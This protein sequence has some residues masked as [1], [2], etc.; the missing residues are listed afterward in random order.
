M[1]VWV[2]PGWG[3]GT[4]APFNGGLN[5]AQ[6]FQAID[7]FSTLLREARITL[8][9][10]SAG[11]KL[12]KDGTFQI[13]FFYEQFLAGVKSADRA[14]ADSLDRRVLA[15]Q[16]GGDVLDPHKE[17]ATS[18]GYNG[19]SVSMSE[20]GSR[21]TSITHQIVDFDL[22]GEINRC[23]KEADA[24][25]ELSFNP[26]SSLARDE[27]HDLTLK[28]DKPGLT[29]RT[30][31]GYYDQ[32]YFYDP[33]TPAAKRVTIAELQQ[34]L[35]AVRGKRDAEVA[36]EI[37]N[38]ELA[39]RLSDTEAA[40]LQG[41]LRGVKSRAA[42]EALAEA[43]AFLDP[44]ASDVPALAPPD[45]AAQQR[46][47]A[48]TIDYLHKTMKTLPDLFATRTTIRYEEVREHYDETGRRRISYEPL[49]RV[50]TSKETVLYRNGTEISEAVEKGGTRHAEAAGLN[51]KG[52]FGSIL[53]AARDAAGFPGALTWGRWERGAR[54]RLAVFRFAITQRESRFMV[55]YCC[56]PNGDGTSAFRLLTGYHG[57]IAVNPESGAILRLTLVSD[58]PS[59]LPLYRADT[60]TEYGPA[61]IGGM[62]LLRS[63]T[64]VEYGPVSIGGK[65]YI[66]PVKSISISR[67]RT[68][69]I[70]TGL[71]GEF[72]TFGPFATFMNDVSF[73]DYHVFR[74][75]PRI[76]AGYTEESSHK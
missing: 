2:G 63:D 29:A 59:N 8:F 36:R 45:S 25:Y 37:S 23:V 52:T 68:I 40:A 73:G 76:L 12:A 41:E 53:G 72:R 5:R 57:E 1:L 3:E 65:I 16:S 17:L 54:G 13:A 31:T 34:R 33:P 62:P 50:G 58:L 18:F 22:A 55:S 30:R 66:C 14:S 48:L 15:V 51:T 49:H 38:L 4:G 11:E 56:L 35:E 21:S 7:W 64:L 74:A 60:H 46:M 71:P 20:T 42:L 69:K 44:P 39:E 9:T 75:E 19:N 28:V 70:V 61:E 43:S 6:L 10:L 32:P 24:F 67:S 47:I 27:Y 26:A